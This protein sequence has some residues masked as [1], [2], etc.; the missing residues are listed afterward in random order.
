MTI[1]YLWNKLGLV[2]LCCSLLMSCSSAQIEKYTK[3]KKPDIKFKKY[4]IVSVSDIKVRLNILF[5]VHNPNDIAIDSFFLNYELF[6]NEKS[7]V[8][9]LKVKLKLI[10]K[11]NSIITLPIN[12]TYENLLSSVSSVAQL[13]VKGKRNL[14]MAADIEIF[15]KFKVVELVKHDFRF[16]KKVNMNVPLPKYSMNDVMQFIQGV[17]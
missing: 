17:R 11:G 7:F 4:Q 9:G 16:Q 10:P 14:P 3:V 1:K 5:D 2:F 13:I 12:I 8:K 15:G 6:V